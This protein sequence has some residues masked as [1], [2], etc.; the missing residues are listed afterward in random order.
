M[1]DKN[2]KSI[3]KKKV[4]NEEQIDNLI[5]NLEREVSLVIKRLKDGK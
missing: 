3:P 5:L 1:K 4:L 2:P